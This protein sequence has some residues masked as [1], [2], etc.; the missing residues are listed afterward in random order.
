MTKQIPQQLQ[1]IFKNGSRT[2]FYSSI[3]FPEAV[4]ADVFALYSF[5]RT[6]DDFVDQTPPQAKQFKKF[7]RD[8]ETSLS[9]GPSGSLVIDSF[10]E[11]Q[12]KRDFDPEWVEVFLN[13]MELDLK[14]KTY[15]EMKDTVS[16]MHGS[17]EVIGLMMS[18]IL[19]LPVYAYSAAKYLGRS[20][21]YVNFIRDIKEDNQLGRVYFPQTELK[22]YGLKSLEQNVVEKYPE[23]YATFM[24]AQIAQYEE[25]SRQGQEGYSS[26]PRRFLIPIKTANDLYHWTAT[27]IAKRP[28]VVFERKVK[29]SI[30]RVLFTLLK[31]TVWSV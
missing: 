30:G 13:A 1:K 26:I 14:Q 4:K 9:G 22:K 8:Y 6:A 29:P 7:R 2:Y 11:L 10:V 19:E 17:A 18:K 3:F 12:K 15:A 20:M 5:V 24:A 27:E 21:Q 28:M 16:Y 23:R 25:W 31:N